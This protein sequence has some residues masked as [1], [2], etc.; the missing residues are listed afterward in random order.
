MKKVITVSLV[1]IILFSVISI[2]SVEAFDFFEWL[3]GVFSSSVPLYIPDVPSNVQLMRVRS[4]GGCSNYVCDYDYCKVKMYNY[5]EDPDYCA[6]DVYG[7]APCTSAIPAYERGETIGPNSGCPSNPSYD[8]K[9]YCLYSVSTPRDEYCLTDPPVKYTHCD[10]DPNYSN[11]IKCS[12]QCSAGQRTAVSKT[13][14]C[15]SPIF[16]KD[17]SNAVEYWRAVNTKEE[18]NL[19]IIGAGC[20]DQQPTTTTVPITTT[21][22]TKCTNCNYEYCEGKWAYKNPACT[23]NGVCYW[24]LTDCSTQGKIC[25]MS[26]GKAICVIGTVTTTTTTPPANDCTKFGLQNSCPPDQFCAPVDMGGNW[27]CCQCQNLPPQECNDYPEKPCEGA[28][29]QDY[30]TCVWATTNC[31]KPT[32][33][34]IQ[35]ETTTTTIQ[36]G[37]CIMDK[38]CQDAFFMCD[39]ICSGGICTAKPPSTCQSQPYYVYP[40]CGSPICPEGELINSLNGCCESDNPFIK[41]GWVIA[42]IAL[43]ACLGIWMLI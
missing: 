33:T 34:T 31:Y 19:Y 41:Y 3:R 35:G 11:R 22:I 16:C 32:T 5:N 15:N 6:L 42:V 21:T 10:C 43:I 39:L 17:Y 13:L 30:P 28:V 26:S 29:W 20:T 9:C 1:S 36:G 4:G 12:Y 8:S 38:E 7:N 25:Q 18:G 23:S 40:D 2:G 27:K 24:Q 14:T 37:S